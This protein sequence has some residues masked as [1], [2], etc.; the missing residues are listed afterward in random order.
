MTQETNPVYIL[1]ENTKVYDP[2]SR[3]FVQGFAGMPVVKRGNGMF[4]PASAQT[5]GAVLSDYH[6]R[7]KK[8]EKLSE[9]QQKFYDFYS[10]EEVAKNFIPGGKL[11][12]VPPK[13]DSKPE[14]L[15]R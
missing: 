8:G 11:D 15:F 6:E 13:Q 10:K 2:R 4:V 7:L 3:S 1:S 14:C 12:G 5:V 9:H